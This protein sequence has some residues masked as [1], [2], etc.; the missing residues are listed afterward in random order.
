M[1]EFNEDFAN[2]FQWATLVFSAMGNDVSVPKWMVFLEALAAGDVSLQPSPDEIIKSI[3]ADHQASLPDALRKMVVRLSS[4]E[5]RRKSDEVNR[6]IA[7]D[8]LAYLKG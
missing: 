2:G 6:Q 3:E 7:N 5:S 1:T 4:G 8:F